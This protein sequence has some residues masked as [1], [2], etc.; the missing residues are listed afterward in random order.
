MSP[1]KTAER[2]TDNSCGLVNNQAANPT[3]GLGGFF[4]VRLRHSSR[5][6]EIMRRSTASGG[7]QIWLECGN[8]WWAYDA[9]D[10]LS[11]EICF[12]GRDA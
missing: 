11:P 7:Q 4:W 10:V 12:S 2:Q 8:D 9:V 5:P 1:N 6:P 3:S